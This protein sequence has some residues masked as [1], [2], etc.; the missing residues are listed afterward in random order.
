MPE[1]PEKR[2]S[3]NIIGERVRLARQAFNPPLTQDQVVGRLA[4]KG[5][6]LDRVALTKL[7]TG[8]RCAFDFEVKALATVLQVDAHWLL[9]ITQAKSSSAR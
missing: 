9:G 6:Q 2:K 4:K 3:R 7:E 5:V 8:A 1:K